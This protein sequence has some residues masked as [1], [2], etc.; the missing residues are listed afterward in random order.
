MRIRSLLAGMAFAAVLT[1]CSD[2][3]PVGPSPVSFTQVD[4]MGRAA[5]STVFLPSSAKDAYNLAAPAEH[6]ATYKTHV[7]AFLTGVAGYTAAAADQLGDVLM[8]D[9][10]TVD[11]AQPS[12]Y[13]N[14]RRPADDVTTA[15][16]ML[17]FGAG[18]PLSDDN[19]D[20]NDKPY[21]SVF[22]YLAAPHVP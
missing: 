22:P 5:I 20:D 13:L 3:D 12:G 15:S 6:R 19:V 4:Y 11:L 8:P 10:L 16:L 7:V 17:V 21:P 1:G 9:I 18:T 2:D 14:G